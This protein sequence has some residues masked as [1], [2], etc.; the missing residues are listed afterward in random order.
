MERRIHHNEY[1]IAA[2]GMSLLSLIGSLFGFFNIISLMTTYQV[3]NQAK[4]HGLTP[5]Q[6]KIISIL[7]EAGLVLTLCISVL[8]M[9]IQL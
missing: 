5:Q 4:E 6:E 7:Y 3:I 8:Y 9:T 1:E 2:I